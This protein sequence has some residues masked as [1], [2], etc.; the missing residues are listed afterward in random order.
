[1]Y[2]VLMI[3][4]VQVFLIYYIIKT[5]NNERLRFDSAMKGSDFIIWIYDR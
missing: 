5:T 4:K 1:M 2:I 3:N